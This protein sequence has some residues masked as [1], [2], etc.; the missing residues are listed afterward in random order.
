MLL[1][2]RSARHTTGM[3][4]GGGANE[5]PFAWKLDNKV[6][7]PDHSVVAVLERFDP[8]LP[9]PATHR[10]PADNLVCAGQG[11]PGVLSRL[12]G[13]AVAEFV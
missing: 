1:F 12:D 13:L 2:R 4:I 6:A 10:Q 5:S 3:S 9:V 8:I 11:S 7:L